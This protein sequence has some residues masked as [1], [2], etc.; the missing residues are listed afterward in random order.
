MTVTLELG[1]LTLESV[2]FFE[3][4]FL[5]E[6]EEVEVEEEEVEEEEM[7]VQYHHWLST[8]TT[9]NHY[10]NSAVQLLVDT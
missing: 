9:F 3:L 2:F 1:S 4:S 8:H 10:K 5:L 7:L 6:E